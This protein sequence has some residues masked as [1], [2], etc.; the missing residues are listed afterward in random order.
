[1]RALIFLSIIA[2]ANYYVSAR[3]FALAPIPKVHF[4]IPIIGALVFCTLIYILVSG[5]LTGVVPY[6]TLNVPSPVAHALQQLGV[7]WAAALV[8]TGVITGLTTVMLVL[9]YGLT[10]IIFAMSRDGLLSPYFSKVNDKTHT[11]VRTTALCGIAMAITAGF[12][13]FQALAELVNVGTLAAFVLVCAGV[14]VLRI[15]QPDLPR[16]FKAPFGL[17]LPILGVLSC[18]ALM[19]FLPWITHLRFGLWLLVGVVVYFA[20]SYNSSQLA[21]P[22][23]KLSGIQRIIYA[24]LPILLVLILGYMGMKLMQF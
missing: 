18:G 8:A 11:P 23:N 7:N 1:M 16:P 10:R 24:F 15:K 4:I 9:Y 20:Y 21:K 17:L 12:L 5:L 19:A 14:I 13:P 2:F 3:L 22:E 6:D